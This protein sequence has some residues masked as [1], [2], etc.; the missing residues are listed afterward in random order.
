MDQITE[1]ITEFIEN[2]ATLF[3]LN[4]ESMDQLDAAD[5]KDRAGKIWDLVETARQLQQKD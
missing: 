2:V 4:I 1:E 3:P 5:F